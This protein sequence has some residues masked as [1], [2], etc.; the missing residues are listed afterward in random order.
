MKLSEFLRPDRIVVPL[1][2]TTLREAARTLH[3]RLIATGAVAEPEKLAQ[4]IQEMRGEDVVALG[5]RAF[6]IHFRTDAV[7]DIAVAVG[8][9]ARDI[10]RELGAEEMQHARLAL[11]IVSPPRMAAR[12][13]QV[14]GAFARVLARPGVVDELVAATDPAQVMAIG[15]FGEIELP[16]QLAVSDIMTTRPRTATQDTPLRD[17]AR[18]MARAGIS[19][20]P[21]V[22]DN[23]VIVGMLGERELLRHL[24]SSYLQGDSPPRPTPDGVNARRAVRDAMTRQVLCVSPE[25]PLAEVASLMIN[26]DVEQVPVV[27][28]GRLVGFLTR[29]D[30]VRKL[31]GW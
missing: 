14:L 28:E 7:R 9:A 1:E 18:E 6:L 19:A 31:I 5:E 23:A 12:Y 27:S 11:M 20:L 13:L 21:V 10:V 26:K 25:Q 22:E 17:A 8:I 4:R 29:G 16:K 30:I 2:A 15:A 3:D 24:L